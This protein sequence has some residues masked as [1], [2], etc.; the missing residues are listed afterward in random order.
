M[1]LTKIWK[2]PKS[3]QTKAPLK[4][5]FFKPPTQFAEKLH[6]DQL[7]KSYKENRK[8]NVFLPEA[9]FQ[10]QWAELVAS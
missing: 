2:M 4:E 8:A 3:S 1:K 7:M 5:G 10:T 9:E 6:K